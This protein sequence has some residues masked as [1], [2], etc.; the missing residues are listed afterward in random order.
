MKDNLIAA[1]RLYPNPVSENM[2]LWFDLDEGE[3][4]LYDIKGRLVKDG[5]LRHGSNTIS[6]IE[7]PPGA[8]LLKVLHRSGVASLKLIKE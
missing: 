7:L 2:H 3:F 1:I 8:Y 6:I 5:S 4:I